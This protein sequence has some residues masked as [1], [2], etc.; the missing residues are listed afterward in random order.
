MMIRVFFQQQYHIVEFP[1]VFEGNFAVMT[2]KARVK[3]R[4][5]QQ[6]GQNRRMSIVT[7]F[8]L[9][10]F[11]YRAVDNAALLYQVI[12]FL[13]T[14]DAQLSW[15]VQ[16]LLGPI[17]TVRIMAKDAVA[18]HRRM[19]MAGL[20]VLLYLF[21]VTSHTKLISLGDEELRFPR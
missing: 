15:L 18:V 8:A 20:S 4:L 21:F 12:D 5:L 16:K 7:G 9:L 10:A 2:A 6:L 3:G 19:K 1:A 11:V 17:R 13:V 14:G